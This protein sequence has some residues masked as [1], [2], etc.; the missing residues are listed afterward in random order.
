M[1]SH[2]LD[3]ARLYGPQKGA[4]PHEVTELEAR[5]ASMQ[6][7]TPFAALPGS[8]A[9]GGLGA[10]FAALG[11]ELVAG[12]AYVLDRI[13]FRERLRGVDLAVSGEGTLDATTRE[14]KAPWEARRVAEGEGVRCALFGGRVLVDG[15]DFHALSGDPGQASTDLR[16]LGRRLGES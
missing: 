12:A 9:A 3:A 5:L 13:D 16:L 7:L 15:A 2:L 4:S 6:D 10:A 1:R 11:A 14:G 8:G